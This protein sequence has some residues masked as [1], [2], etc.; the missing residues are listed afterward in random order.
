MIDRGHSDDALVA[1]IRSSIRAEGRLF[2]SLLAAVLAMSAIFFCVPQFHI[3]LESA[4]IAALAVLLV[5]IAIVF[6]TKS[7]VP[8]VGADYDESVLRRT[9]DDQHRRWRWLFLFVF[10]AVGGLA[11]AISL[12]VLRPG[13]GA[14]LPSHNPLVLVMA[15]DLAM[16]AVF[17]VFQVCFGPNFLSPTWRRALNDE[18]TRA[19]Q[20]SAA[21]FGYIFCVIA[22]GAISVT[23]LFRPQWGIAVM[24]GAVAAAIILPG[25][26]F[27]VRQWRAER[28]G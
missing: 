18:F 26:Y 5:W 16:A 23:G 6:W 11:I 25:L 10:A 9:I 24:P 12:S 1:R 7:T 21:T 8:L 14:A 13:A 4:G 3:S 17:A 19:L 2:W 15:T 27:L 28:D 22:M 20:N